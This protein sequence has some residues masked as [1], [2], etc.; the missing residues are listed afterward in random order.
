MFGIVSG[1][2]ADIEERFGGC[3]G[4]QLSMDFAA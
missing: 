3:S 4:E 2:F 1:L